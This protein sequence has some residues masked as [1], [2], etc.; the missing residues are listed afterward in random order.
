MDIW[1]AIIKKEIAMKKI[2]FLTTL[3]SVGNILIAQTYPDPEFSNEIYYL[4]KDN[5]YT[6]VRL[7]KGSSKMETKTKLGGLG[8]AES[9]YIIEGEKSSVRLS[10]G[11]N[12]SFIFSTGASSSSSKTSSNNSDSM[13]QANGI[14]PSKISGMMSQMNDPTSMITLYKTD[15]GKGE[16]KIILQKNGGANPFAS[17]KI[18]SSDKFT[19]SAKKIRDGYWEFIIDKSLSK[20]EYAFAMMAMGMGGMG[21][22]IIF[23]FGID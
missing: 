17:H 1:K 10:G 21:S 2:F 20:G 14:D 5:G 6:L 23:S 7:E 16:R 8:G 3:I 19:F 13:M 18:Q 11:K 22:Q 4:N 9:G 12:L 15:P